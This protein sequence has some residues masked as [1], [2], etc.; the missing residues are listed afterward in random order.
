MQLKFSLILLLF[1]HSTSNIFA[2]TSNT[3][4]TLQNLLA[5]NKPISSI[6]CETIKYVNIEDTVRSFPQYLIKTSKGL[7]VFVNGSGRLYQLINNNSLLES[8]RI[9]STVFFGYSLGSFPFVYHDTIYSLGG[10]GIWRIN[11]QLRIYVEKAKQW[12]IVAL[13]EEIPVLID[14]RNTMLWYDI[15]KG[16]IYIGWS[17]QRNQAIKSSSLNET[18]F[19]YDVSVLE[20]S[21]KNWQKLGTLSNYLKE[22]AALI[23]NI[24][25]S[26]WGQLVGFGNKLMVID[27]TNN[28]LLYLKPARNEAISTLLFADPDTRLY[29]FRDSTL[30]F[31]NTAK[32]RLDSIQLHINDFL[33]SDEVI[34]TPFKTSAE[35]ILTLNNYWIYSVSGC[36][37]LTAIGLL[38]WKKRKSFARKDIPING[39]LKSADEKEIN[40]S[41]SIKTNVQ[42][43]ELHINNELKN[44]STKATNGSNF[45]KTIFEEK[46][47][48]LLTA[49]YLNSSQGRTT[50]IEELNKILGVMQKNIE[51]QKRQ[52]SD[53]IISINKK[54]SLLIGKQETIIERK[55]T[56]FDKRSFHYFIEHMKIEEVMRILEN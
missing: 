46:E 26:P 56:D 22:K 18:N 4:I 32:N 15:E 33:I 6:T 17:M 16:K 11:G 13:N 42:Q 35:I 7:F 19:V 27:Y 40:N 12:D 31:G 41:N 43:K 39:K 37:V 45:I 9:D 53:T 36:M 47:L 28:R 38:M 1:I 14:L 2:Q 23:G 51:I 30:Y 55:K 48:L 29:Y 44:G 10:Y 21:T 34:Y 49:I 8:R 25:S 20:L 50:S 5:G 54:Y 3:S 52:R 24:T